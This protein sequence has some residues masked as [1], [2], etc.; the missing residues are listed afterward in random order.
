MSDMLDPHECPHARK[1][2]TYKTTAIGTRQY[3]HQ[4]LDC[5]SAIGNPIKHDAVRGQEVVEFDEE[6]HDRWRVEEQRRWEVER[7]EKNSGWWIWY[8]SYLESPDWQSRRRKV[9]ERAGGLCE[10][11]RECRATQVHHL[12][13]AHAGN[14]LLYE[15]AALCEGC[16]EIAH[17]DKEEEPE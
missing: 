2:L 8:N 13:Y 5:G 6:L 7:E 17:S 4:C 14:E 15:L 12:T 9:L 16:H 3:K 10:G 1:I 11:C